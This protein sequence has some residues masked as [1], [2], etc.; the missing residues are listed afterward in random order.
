M[1]I[2]FS[3]SSAAE[4]GSIF[5]EWL[6]N[7]C[8]SPRTTTCRT[9]TP[10]MASAAANASDDGRRSSYSALISTVGH[11]PSST[12]SPGIAYPSA[13]LSGPPR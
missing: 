9:S 5:A 1:M 2:G 4:I 10:A 11:K 12:A 6:R 7:P 8:S 13:R 3:K